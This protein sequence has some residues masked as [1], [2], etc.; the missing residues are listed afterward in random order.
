MEKTPEQKDRDNPFEI[1]WD[2]LHS[3]LDAPETSTRS[4]S[5]E[6]FVDGALPIESKPANELSDDGAVLNE[7]LSFYHYGR[8]I[9]DTELSPKE[10]Q[11]LAGLLYPHR[12]L[13]HVRHEY[14]VCFV[15]DDTDAPVRPFVQIFDGLIEKKEGDGETQRR[16]QHHLLQLELVVRGLAATK[17]GERL[18]DLYDLAS[19]QIMTSSNLSAEKAALLRE[20]LETARRG[21]PVDGAVFPCNPEIPSRLFEASKAAFWFARKRDF[22]L[23]LDTLIR[24]VQDILTADYNRSDEAKSAEHLREE[25][26]AT[27][28]DDLDFNVMSDILSR[29][30]LGDPLPAERRQRIEESLKIMSHVR[31]MYAG[32]AIRDR[33]LPFS[34]ETQVDCKMAIE[35]YHARMAIMTEFFKAVR[36]ARLEVEN[37]YR[38]DKH[39]LFFEQFDPTCLTADELSCCPP[40]LI[41]LGRKFFEKGDK[42]AILEL[43]SSGLP[44]KVLAEINDVC[45]QTP[46]GNLS[47]SPSWMSQLAAMAVAINHV[48]VLQSTLSKPIFIQAGMI[49]GLR[50]DGPALFC[51]YTGNPEHQPRLD[52]FLVAAAAEESRLF[53]SYVYDPGKGDSQAERFSIDNNPHVE[54]AW[55]KEQFSYMDGNQKPLTV[56]LP[57]TPADFF[58]ADIRLDRY[59][60]ALPPDKWHVNMVPIGEFLE[61][62]AEEAN[63]KIPFITAVNSQGQVV[64]VVVSRPLLPVVQR[65]AQS[66]RH[67]QE[68][69][70]INNSY[71]LDLLARE[72]DRCEAQKNEE[73]EAIE[74]KYAAELKKDIGE[75]SQEIIQRIAGQLIA[76]GPATAG[77][78]SLPRETIVTTAAAPVAEPTGEDRETTES[79]EEEEDDIVSFDDPYIDTPLCTSCND[80][81]NINGQMFGYNENK[82]A[83]IKDVAAGPF[84]HLVLAAEKCP[85]HIIHPGK[86]KNSDEPNLEGLIARAARFNGK[87]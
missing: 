6:V 28:E 40:V 64:R 81:T 45:G 31:P 52:R 65:V 21:L 69:G 76:G 24:H 25:T 38:K 47:V 73:V 36:I 56:E 22:L 42:T 79:T 59:F 16:F 72:K 7:L 78:I 51:V 63:H 32:A 33:S 20:D 61:T 43:L 53:P 37:R 62:P 57:F 49:E 60:R 84:E 77:P 46:D 58:Q 17:P 23:E 75:L 5:T 10:D 15:E 50:Y 34:M 55:S 66:W 19:K 11:P 44:F 26:G 80:C 1:K 2:V 9:P 35:Q 29:S 4:L 18:T 12:D 68:L 14:P 86:P 8:R 27:M 83:F 71:A 54:E 30:N 85:V 87:S 74:K 48:Y 67:L 13:L 41:R 82:Q 39:E 3:E 70:G